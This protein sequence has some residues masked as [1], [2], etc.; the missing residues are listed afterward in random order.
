MQVERMVTVIP[1]E[2]A[3]LDI[4]EMRQHHC[5]GAGAVRLVVVSQ[6]MRGCGGGVQHGR[7]WRAVRDVVEHGIVP[8]VGKLG[9]PHIEVMLDVCGVHGLLPDWLELHVVKGLVLRH[10]RLAMLHLSTLGVFDG[11]SDIHLQRFGRIVKH[12]GVHV[13]MKLVVVARAVFRRHQHRVALARSHAKRLYRQLFHVLAI[14]LDHVHLVAID[15]HMEHGNG[16][17]VDE[18]QPV[19]LAGLELERHVVIEAI[20]VV[21]V[22]IA[23]RPGCVD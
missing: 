16:R 1:V 19:G 10:G 2:H 11:A 20:Q 22:A 14:R 21:S 23:R 18:A 15:P 13:S 17:H 5:V 3:D 7:E 9:Q 4:L 6:F 8:P 12:V